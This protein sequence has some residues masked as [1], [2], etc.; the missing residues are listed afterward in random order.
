MQKNLKTMSKGYCTCG[1]V[2]EN[3]DTGECASCGSARRKAERSAQKPVKVYRIAKVSK[4]RV[5][6]DSEY[7]REKAKFLAGKMCPIYANLKA[8]DIHHMKG[9]IG[10]LLMDKR[11]WL[12]V[13]R[14]AHVKIELNPKWAREQ[15]YSLPRS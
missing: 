5:K 4:K 7:H 14:K 12:A 9:R 2:S 10:L 1:K 13:S 15:G 6:I 8:E 3:K 11:Y